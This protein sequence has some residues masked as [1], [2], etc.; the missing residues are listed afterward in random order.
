MQPGRA[1]DEQHHQP[2]VI[3]EGLRQADRVTHDRTAAVAAHHIGRPHTR[4][5]L[6]A[7]PGDRERRA[8]GLVR[9][10]F[11]AP[12]IAALDGVQFRGARRSTVRWHIAAVARCP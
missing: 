9:E 12:A 11:G 3:G 4:R 7:A 1:E 5:P 10:P 8:V 6:P 2:V